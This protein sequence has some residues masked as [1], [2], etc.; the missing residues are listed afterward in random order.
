MPRYEI[1]L[2]QTLQCDSWESYRWPTQK[3]EVC[4]YLCKDFPFRRVSRRGSLPMGHAV[5]SPLTIPMLLDQRRPGPS[6]SN[7]LP[8]PPATLPLQKCLYSKEQ[9]RNPACAVL[10]RQYLRRRTDES[11]FPF[12]RSTHF[13]PEPIQCRQPSCG[14]GKRRKRALDP[15]AHRCSS[16]CHPRSLTKSTPRM[17]LENCDSV[18]LRK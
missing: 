14:L 9:H 15:N 5:G 8:F 13:H 17:A 7:P 1:S 6:S 16:L 11:L 2:E 12:H 10:A 18:Y 3:R 4:E